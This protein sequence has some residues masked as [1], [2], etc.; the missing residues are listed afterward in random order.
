M[1]DSLKSYG[2]DT[3]QLKGVRVG[4]V[5]MGVSG[6]A[7]CRTCL[8]RGAVPFVT[9]SGTTSELAGLIALM[10]EMGIEYETGGHSDRFVDRS[11]LV[12][13]SPGV[14]W[15][16]PLLERARRMG[17]PVIGEVEFAYRLTEARI[18]GVTGT[19][20]KSTVVTLTGEML[21]AG[22]STVLVAGNIG[23]ALSG[24]VDGLDEGYT[25]VTELSSFQLEGISAFRPDIA[26]ILNITP[27][28]MDRHRDMASYVR[29]KA[30]IFRNMTPEDSLVIPAGDA[31][32]ATM[33]EDARCRK[34]Y[35]GTEESSCRGTFMVDS[36]AVSNVSGTKET[37][38]TREDIRLTGNHNIM[39]VLAAATCARLAGAFPGDIARAV[40][41]FTGLEHR[42]ERVGVL[43]GVTWV[44]D[45]KG[46]NV[47]AAINALRS[48]S[49]PVVWIAGG[50][51]KGLDFSPLRKVAESSVKCAVLIGESAPSLQKALKGA[52]EIV[53][54]ATMADAVKHART[55]GVPG[56]VVLLS[57]ACASFDMFENFE[58][59][60]RVFK[61]I[62]KRLSHEN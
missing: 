21:G 13:V 18:L 55:I 8:K 48:F 17:K 24:V 41:S 53:S 34:F 16:L 19:N 2:Q 43:D 59:R 1:S 37:L 22:S 3:L 56:D 32:I 51:D 47:E 52:V 31:L 29:A 44:N 46:T 6:V 57:P 54:A 35:F 40:R 36:T 10:E 30:N 45:S 26:A 5:G 38:F 49:A 39:N 20:G 14:P 12:V 28:H 15:D 9:D 58:H 7:L 4:I 27:D 42:M 60:G 50:S 11:E 61:D 62:V 25:V 33:A 23:T